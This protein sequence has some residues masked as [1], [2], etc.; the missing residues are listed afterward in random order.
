[1][2]LGKFKEFMAR[3]SEQVEE[4]WPAV[5]EVAGV[6]YVCSGGGMRREEGLSGER[7]G[8]ELSATV[9][10]RVSKLVMAEAPRVG[11]VVFYSG[12]SVG[13]DDAGDVELVECV[14]DGVTEREWDVSWGITL[15]VC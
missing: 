14:V 11:D 5:L 7:G 3:A 10:V 6:E 9:Q 8:M 13:A 2:D 1:M 15:M 4:L 12:G